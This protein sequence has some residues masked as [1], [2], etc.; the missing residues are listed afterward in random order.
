MHTILGGITYTHNA[1]VDATFDLSYMAKPDGEGFIADLEAMNQNLSINKG[2]EMC[3]NVRNVCTTREFRALPMFAK[4]VSKNVPY[5]RNPD[6][7]RPYEASPYQA[8]PHHRNPHPRYPYGG[9]PYRA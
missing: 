4:T 6:P 8:E 7:R 5:E 9:H 2:L 1:F 3:K